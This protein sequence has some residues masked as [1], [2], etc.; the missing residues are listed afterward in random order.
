MF[1]QSHEVQKQKRK[2]LGFDQLV[3]R[4]EET[5]AASHLVAEMFPDER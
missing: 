2:V 4:H 3:Q 1:Q 5:L